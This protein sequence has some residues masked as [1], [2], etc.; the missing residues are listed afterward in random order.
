M[1]NLSKNMTLAAA[2]TLAMTAMCGS[3]MAQDAVAAPAAVEAVPDNVV[4]YNVALTSDYRYRGLSQSRLKPAISGGADYTHNPTGL[5]VGTW[6]SSIKWIKDGGGDTNLEWDIYGGK[7]GEISKDF[8]YDV[9]GLYYFYPSNGL[10]TNA[11][12]FELYGQLGYGPMYVKYSHSTTNLFGVADSKNSGYLDV[13]ANVEVHDGYI[14]NLHAG[15]QKVEHNDS[16]SYSDYK[17]G[18]TKDFGVATVSLAAV[19][20][21]NVSL[22]PN[23]K[24]LAKSGLVLT[25]SKTF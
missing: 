7:R 4:S 1:K 6:L 10:S 12:T 11:N 25:V 3:A 17:I 23:G 2:L 18:V 22:A 13:G 9:G 20:A 24:N 5:Y 21:N 8:T 14:L 19:K 16:L 15:R